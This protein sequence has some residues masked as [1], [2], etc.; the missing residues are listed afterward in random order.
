M[1]KGLLHRM[2][3][4]SLFCAHPSRKQ[5][6]LKS[7]DRLQYRTAVPVRVFLFFQRTALVRC[8]IR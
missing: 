7:P 8:S 2:G 4:Q 5:S 3:W 6:D 1:K